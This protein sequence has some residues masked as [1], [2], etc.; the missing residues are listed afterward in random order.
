MNRCLKAPALR[1]GATLLTV[2]ALGLAHIASMA[3]SATYPDSAAVPAV[4]PFP[5][6][7]VRAS[8]VVTRPPEVLID[9]QPARVSP[10]ARI[11]GANNMLVM[12]GSIVGQ[13]YLVNLVREHTGLVHDVWILTPAEARLERPAATRPD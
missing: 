11:R 9:G 12:S 13:R 1:F 4:R 8:M 2:G 10:G 6:A 3:Q 5:A 7:A